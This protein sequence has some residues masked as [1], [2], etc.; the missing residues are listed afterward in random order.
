MEGLIGAQKKWE[1][2]DGL[3]KTIEDVQ[4][5]ID[6]ISR[7]KG[8][9]AHGTISVRQASVHDPD[10]GLGGLDPAMTLVKLKNPIKDSFERLNKDAKDLHA[11]ITNYGKQLDKVKSQK[12]SVC[13]KWSLT[14][15]LSASSHY[16][17]QIR[18]LTTRTS[19]T[20]R[21]ACTC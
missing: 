16:I 10:G 4:Q 13:W 17:W 8:D 12:E 5:I 9:I 21:S 6:L 14:F 15:I 3:E 1:R 19:S 11:A 18:R 7:S 20:E 2:L